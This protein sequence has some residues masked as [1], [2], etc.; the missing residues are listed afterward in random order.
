[1][2]YLMR[3]KFLF[4]KGPDVVSVMIT[5]RDFW[6]SYRATSIQVTEWS[7]YCL[8]SHFLE[9]QCFQHSLKTLL[10]QFHAECKAF[11]CT[12]LMNTVF[13]YVHKTEQFGLFGLQGFSRF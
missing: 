11:I 12:I 9:K 5:A 2:V 7:D 4:S 8:G 1:M 6:C 10:C 13:N 3:E